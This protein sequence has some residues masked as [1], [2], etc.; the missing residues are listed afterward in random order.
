VDKSSVEPVSIPASRGFEITGGSKSDFYKTWIG[1]G[2][3][4]PVD[5]GCRGQSVIVAEVK[6]AVLKRTEM[7]RS[8]EI[9]PRVR[10]AGAK[11]GALLKGKPLS[12]KAVAARAARK[13]K[14]K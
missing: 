9:Q 12:P 7:I 11:V 13:S 14:R 1:E 2:W 4:K 5:L 6:A 10:N 3:V 8:G